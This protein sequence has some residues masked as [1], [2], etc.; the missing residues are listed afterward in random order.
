MLGKGVRIG[1][2]STTVTN[3]LHSPPHLVRISTSTEG[4]RVEAFRGKVPIIAYPP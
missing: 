4:I 3:I 1:T 2:S